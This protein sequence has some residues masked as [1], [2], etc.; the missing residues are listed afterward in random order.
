MPRWRWGSRGSSEVRVGF[1]VGGSSFFAAIEPFHG[2]QVVLYTENETDRG[3]LMTRT[4]I[5]EQ[6]KSGHALRVV[7]LDGD[8]VEEIVAGF[9]DPTER[10]IGPGINVYKASGAAA[11]TKWEKHVI[12]DKGIACEDLACDDLNADGK[13]DIVACGRATRNVRIYW[14]QGTK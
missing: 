12:D 4:V 5:D 13:I 2:H 8:G 14:N 1:P 9:R 10:G 11:L 3:G 6:L 7:D